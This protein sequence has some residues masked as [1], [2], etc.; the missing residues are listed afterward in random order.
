VGLTGAVTVE[1]GK[2]V[3]AGVAWFGMGAT[4]IKARQVEAA[5]V[6]QPI[7][8]LDVQGLAELAVADTAPFDDHHATSEYR[9]TVGRRLFARTLTERLGVR[10]SA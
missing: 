5:L 10:K 7:A 8:N 4:P 9:R 3:R 6:G 1:N 2:I